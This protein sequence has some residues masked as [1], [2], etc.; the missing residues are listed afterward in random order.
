MR[1]PPLRRVSL[2]YTPADA[3]H[4]NETLCKL[5]FDLAADKDSADKIVKALMRNTRLAKIRFPDDQSSDSE[6]DA[7]HKAHRE[8]AAD[9]RHRNEGADAKAKR[10]QRIQAQKEFVEKKRREEEEKKHPGAGSREEETGGRV[11]AKEEESL[12]KGPAPGEHYE[13]E[14]ILTGRPQDDDEEKRDAPSARLSKAPAVGGAG[15]GASIPSPREQAEPS[16]REEQAEEVDSSSPKRGV[17]VKLGK[18]RGTAKA[19]EEEPARTK[20]GRIKTAAEITYGTDSEEEQE[21]VAGEKEEKPKEKVDDADRDDADGR[22][23]APTGEG[24]R[25]EEGEAR[26]AAAAGEARPAAA[27]GEGKRPAAAI[28][29]G[30]RPEEGE[31]RPAAAAG[32]GKRLAAATGEA[33]AEAEQKQIQESPEEEGRAEA[34]RSRR[35]QPPQQPATSSAA[36]AEQKHFLQWDERRSPQHAESTFEDIA[37]GLLAAH[38]RLRRNP[39]FYIQ[40]L[41]EMRN[42]FCATDPLK[43]YRPGKMPGLGT[44]EG[45]PAVD[46]A[47][48]VLEKNLPTLKSLPSYEWSES[49]SHSAHRHCVQSDFFEGITGHESPADVTGKKP[50]TT[51]K[52]RIL[53]ALGVPENSLSGRERADTAVDQI[54]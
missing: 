1:P 4:D 9:L 35:E 41:T 28:G 31:A 8:M 10:E 49:L 14:E 51:P 38:N 21:E 26:P 46:E 16:P 44:E 5:G 18:A 23:A 17:G 12:L 7:K 11:P 25:P 53:Q 33:R 29:E 27:T 47:I 30:K 32:E 3:L 19:P 6:E 52:D 20:S 36:D 37:R 24:K 34:E 15:E 48:A 54:P 22:T 45:Q 40:N 50:W 13:L 39:E 43:L 42:S 2:C